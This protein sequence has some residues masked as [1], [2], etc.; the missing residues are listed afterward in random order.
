M[1][2]SLIVYAGNDPQYL[3]IVWH[4]VTLEQE[5][6]NTPIALDLAPVVDGLSD[7]YNRTI[8]H[9][10]GIDA[11]DARL[12]SI[13]RGAGVRIADPVTFP[14]NETDIPQEALD[15]IAEAVRSALISYAR[16]PRPDLSKKVWRKLS[17]SIAQSALDSYQVVAAILES[18]SDIDTVYI[19]NG[20]FPHQ[21]A[22]I[23]AARAHVRHIRFYE[24]GEKADSYWLE[25]YSALDRVPSA[26]QTYR[27]RGNHGRAR[28][29]EWPFVARQRI[30]H[31]LPILRR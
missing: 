11:P 27:K 24:K 17:D 20:R 26:C 3:A 1:S 23:E 18:S 13:L 6:G 16:D 21:R 19:P 12:A 14:L 31:L 8:L 10:F 22:A 5:A 9:R 15:G 28:L 29:D 7:S 30:Q 25:D 2:E 4:L